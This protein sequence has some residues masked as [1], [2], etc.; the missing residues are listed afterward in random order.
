MSGALIY[1]LGSHNC[2]RVTH[3][4]SAF[5]SNLRSLRL[6]GVDVDPFWK[7]FLAFIIYLYPTHLVSQD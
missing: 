2:A 3:F 7:M 4:T 1:L 6:G 5:H